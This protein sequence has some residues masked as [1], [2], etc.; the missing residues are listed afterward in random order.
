VNPQPLAYR[1][2]K[3][4]IQPKDT[5]MANQKT[6]DPNSGIN[7]IPTRPQLEDYR[8][9]ELR[10]DCALQKSMQDYIKELRGEGK[11]KCCLHLRRTRCINMFFREQGRVLGVRF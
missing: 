7:E 5:D 11:G 9:L 10:K 8:V 1:V 4:E 2:K 3:E 6:E